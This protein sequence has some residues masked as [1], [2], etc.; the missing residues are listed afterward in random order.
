[1]AFRPDETPISA[2]ADTEDKKLRKE[3]LLGG[4]C[5]EGTLR[6]GFYETKLLSE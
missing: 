2:H 1:M 3:R 6:S 5:F 4:P